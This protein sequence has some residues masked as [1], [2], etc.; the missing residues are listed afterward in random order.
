MRKS[1]TLLAGMAL[2]ALVLIGLTVT[3]DKSSASFTATTTNPGNQFGS[4]TLTMSN[5][6]SAAASLVN[7]SN[8]VPGDTANRTVTIS[9]TGNVGFTYTAAISAAANT[10]LWSDTTNGI[11]VTVKRGATTLFTGAL[12][13]LALAASPTLAASGTDTLTFD[14]SLPVA[15]GNTFQ[16]LTQD[17]T[18]TYTATQLAGAAR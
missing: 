14:F 9:N 16:T 1:T 17:F 15:A 5:D 3:S 18:I 13:N 6:K 12:K 8:M 4:A 10:L 7:L 2:S 11:Q